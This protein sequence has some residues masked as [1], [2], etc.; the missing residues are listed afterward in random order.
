MKFSEWTMGTD[1]V[2]S[3]SDTTCDRL[4]QDALMS[5]RKRAHLLLHE[6]H[7]DPI[8][9]LL[10]AFAPG[11]YIQPH[12]HPEQW[13][14]V[15]LIRGTFALFTF[16]NAGEITGRTELTTT[17]VPVLQIPAGT[18]HTFVAVTPQALLLELKPGPYRTAEFL[19]AFSSETDPSAPHCLR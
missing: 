10:V 4:L 6:S 13:E 9:R 14:M 5:P 17:T 3:I 7:A 18:W 11:S 2:A 12:R 19:D 8:Q 1:G 16:S 15:L